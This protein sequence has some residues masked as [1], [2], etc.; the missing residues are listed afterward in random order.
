MNS[1]NLVVPAEDFWSRQ[2]N[3]QTALFN[4]T[5]FGISTC[6][7]ANRAEILTAA[8]LSA[9]RFSQTVE[10]NGQEIRVQI[11]V[12]PDRGEAMPDNGPEQPIYAGVG[13]WITL[14]ARDGSHGFAH[15]RRREAVLVISLALAA[16]TRWISRYFVDHY[17]LNF[18]L[19]DWAML[20][21][22]CVF[23]P[24]G[25]RLVVM[26]GPH[27]IGKSTTALRLLRAGYSFLADGMALLQPYQAGFKVGG[28]P[29]GEVKLRDD[30][31]GLF[32]EYKGESIAVREQQKTVVDL[33]LTHP[34]QLV[35]RVIIPD[36]IQLCFV[37][38]AETTQT[39]ISE[40]PPDRVWPL[41][42]A[43]TI[44]WDED[45]RLTRNSTILQSFIEQAG[46]Y[47]LALGTDPDSIIVAFDALS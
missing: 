22:S 17:L 12:R 2:F 20:H 31:L 46:L 21:A 10:P 23:D 19:T 14:S 4:C 27:N 37:E 36:S 29:I 13:E 9:A 42:A 1:E 33:R 11:V 8:K 24:R 15:L 28:Y 25:R 26:I 43:N 41:L 34:N 45:A 47:H 5:P 18:I 44:Y 38:R 3:A 40:L 39:K 6:I 35:E 32:P 30:V 16:Q 7:T